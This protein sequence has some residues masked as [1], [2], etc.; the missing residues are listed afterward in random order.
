MNPLPD[1]T[2]ATP[3]R[4]T[5]ALLGAAVLAVHLMLLV[6]DLAIPFS[7][8]PPSPAAPSAV[9]PVAAG[10]A[11][12]TAKPPPPAQPPRA[13]ISTVRWIA[14]TAPPPT[15]LPAAAQTRA[16]L[17]KPPETQPKTARSAPVAPREPAPPIAPAK[18]VESVEVAETTARESARAERGIAPDPPASPT[19]SPPPSDALVDAP[20]AQVPTAPP[21]TLEAN[22][23]NSIASPPQPPPAPPERN[24]P[25]PP[26][27]P[28]ASTQLA[29]GVTG[30]IKGINYSARST[31][32]WTHADGQYR[33]R[34]EVRIPLL[35]SRVQTSTGQVEASGLRPDRFS[36]KS[37]SERAAHFDH[38]QQNIRF[39]NNRPDAALEPGAQDRLSLFMQLAGLLNARPAAYPAGQTI[40]LQVAGTNDAEIW[41]LRVEE[42]AMLEL[43][44]GVLRARRL[45]REPRQPRDSLIDI[46]L[47]PDLAHLPVRIRITQDNGDRIDQQLSQMP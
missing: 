31:L 30:N 25:L 22:A 37:R 12:D 18:S 4:A 5:L 9:A 20:P 24:E 23:G 21:A 28:P 33:A 16:A 43:P 41:R 34:M 46:W 39:S 47:A 14:A 35:G 8:Q 3:R 11:T 36:D 45:V 19:L 42:E 17:A 10:G 2:P 44:A 27:Q 26:A 40:S 38:A 15:A 7:R 1:R 29:Y 32:E 6:G 13:N